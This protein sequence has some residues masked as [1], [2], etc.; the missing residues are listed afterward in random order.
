MPHRYKSGDQNIDAILSDPAVRYHIDAQIRYGQTRALEIVL[1]VIMLVYGVA[2][3]VPGDTFSQR[4]YL[5]VSAFVH[6]WQ[7]G[8]LGIG[9][10][11][12]RLNA[13]RINGRGKRSPIPRVVGCWSGFLFWGAL[14][15]GFLLAMPPATLAASVCP[16]LALAELY[17]ARRASGDLF[18]LDSLGLQAKERQ[19]ELHR[20]A[21]AG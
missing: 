17:S 5:F 12:I 2:L 19:R 3:L 6:E 21:A 20:F 14:A 11:L 15:L 18:V 10:G 9:C 1:A 8:A 7:A 13:L 16:V 4:A